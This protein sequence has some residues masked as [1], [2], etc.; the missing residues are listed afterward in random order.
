MKRRCSAVCIGLLFTLVQA[1]PDAIAEV[2]RLFGYGADVVRERQV[3]GIIEPS[4]NAD[5][6]N[7]QLLWRAARSYYFVGNLTTDNTKTRYY[8]QGI[9]VGQRAVAAKADGVEGHFWLGAT[10]GAYAREKGAF[11][12][13]STV[14]KVRSEMETVIRLN[15]RYEDARGYLALGELDRQ[16]PRLLGGSDKR[17]VQY[18][19]DGLRIAPNNLEIKFALAQAYKDTGR[20]DDARK[21]LQ[22]L[23]Q[24]QPRGPRAH[25]SRATQ[26]KARDMLAKM[27]S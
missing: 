25:E 17:A 21:Q 24:M 8:E 27:G 22:E 26:D 4:L 12:A 16:L 20:K 11:K 15:P 2:D 5:P 14:G 13:L 7:Y 19:E 3:L 1:R 6:N 23:L 10:Y 9:A 18:L